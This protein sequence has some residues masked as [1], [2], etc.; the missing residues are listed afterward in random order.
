VTVHNGSRTV[1]Q[2]RAACCDVALAGAYLAWRSENAV[3]VLD[4]STHR[5][6]YRVETPP[7]EPIAALDVQAN[8]ALALVLGPAPN[9]LA[10]LA[11]RAPGAPGLHRLPLRPLLGP[12]GPSVRMV[13]DRLVIV[14]AVGSTSQL[15]VADLRGHMH[16]LA[17]FSASVERAGQIDAT[18]NHVTWAS[19]HITSTHV[20]CPPP[21]QGRPCRLLK[22]GTETIWLADLPSGAPRPIVH[23]A[24]TDAP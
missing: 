9:G 3:D 20:D 22:T 21:G 10:T 19:R 15:V 12:S 4:L 11:W 24:F 8:G 7:S 6:T 18:D 16:I 1:F 17:R 14:A 23:W 2:H 5:L 13:S